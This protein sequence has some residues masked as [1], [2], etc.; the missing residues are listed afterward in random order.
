MPATAVLLQL[1]QPLC[2]CSDPAVKSGPCGTK[3]AHAA[4]EASEPKAR[5]RG[6][7]EAAP[8]K[9]ATKDAMCA[10]CGHQDAIK[11][12]RARHGENPPHLATTVAG[13]KDLSV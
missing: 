3:K 12:I 11:Q 7:H 6:E 5:K 1:L 9:E 4:Q 13:G 2:C 10:P 8:K